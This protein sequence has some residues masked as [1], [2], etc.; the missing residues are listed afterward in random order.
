MFNKS[1]DEFPI[2]MENVKFT[3]LTI[4]PSTGSLKFSLSFLNQS[5][6]FELFEGENLVCTGTFLKEVGDISE[7]LSKL[8]L[9]APQSNQIELKT[10]EIYKHFRMAG[11]EF[12][13]LFQGVIKSDVN[14]RY[15]IL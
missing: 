9:V 10:E 7:K 6:Q 5:G 4:I 3:R 2:I 15:S 8:T 12:L 11:V 1:T 14:G 13:D